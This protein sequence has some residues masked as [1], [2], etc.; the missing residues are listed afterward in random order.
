M[1]LT[2]RTHPKPIDRRSRASYTPQTHCI[3]LDCASRMSYT[4]TNP[5]RHR[6]QF[7][8]VIHTPN[9]PLEGDP[10]ATYLLGRSSSIAAHLPLP[11]FDSCK[12]IF[13]T[14]H[15]TMPPKP[16]PRGKAQPPTDTRARGNNDD[17][18]HEEDDETRNEEDEDGDEEE[19]GPWPD[20]EEKAIAKVK[21]GP[22]KG[23]KKMAK[24]STGPQ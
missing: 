13:R 7:S 2:R 10:H 18:E 1:L 16:K 22:P 24:N 15:Y 12:N 14:H 21:K 8:P 6:L 17:E 5:I 4:P 9:P 3:P 23:R 19:L 11:F 20:V